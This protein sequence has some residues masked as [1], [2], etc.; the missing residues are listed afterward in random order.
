MFKVYGLIRIVGPG[1]WK[2]TIEII[3]DGQVIGYLDRE[4]TKTGKC[5]KTRNLQGEVMEG[6]CLEWLLKRTA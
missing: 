4:K 6:V 5:T 3:D 1:E 2:Q